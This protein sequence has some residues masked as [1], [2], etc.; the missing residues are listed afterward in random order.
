MDPSPVFSI[1]LPTYNR[2]YLIGDTL[3]SILNQSF[4]DFELLIIDDGSKDNTEEVVSLFP[5]KRIQYFKKQ[6]GERGAARNFGA[7]KARGRYINFFD[8][9]DLM[10]PSHLSV[11][12]EFIKAKDNPEFFHLGYD[13][14]L[15][16]GSLINL[17]NNFQKSTAELVLFDNKLSCNGIFIRKDIASDF[18]FEEN[19]VLASSEDWELWIRLISRFPFHF[20]N[21]VTSSVINHDQ[22][23]LRT[24]AAEKIV[25]RDLFFIEKLQQDPIVMKRYG[26]SFNRFVADRFT[27]FMLCF[28][29][30]KKKKE[31]IHWA[32]ESVKVRPLSIFSIR[33]LASLKNILIK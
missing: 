29:E 23:S 21:E 20:S 5:D 26:P 19:R 31:V 33:F 13:Y 12:H 8:S 9:D 16:D 27:F 3:K 25:N 7:F 18:P 32:V 22:R 14:K 4:H 1:V 15:E 6:N 11:A 28:A 17:V 30:Q 10:Y 2:A 24:I